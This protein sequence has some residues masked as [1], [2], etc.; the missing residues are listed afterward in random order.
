MTGH[1]I[2][3]PLATIRYGLRRGLK[4]LE[5]QVQPRRLATIDDLGAEDSLSSTQQTPGI[6]PSWWLR[7]R[8]RVGTPEPGGYIQFRVN[9]RATGRSSRSDIRSRLT[10]TVLTL[11]LLASLWSFGLER[12][13]AAKR[14]VSVHAGMANASAVAWISP[15]RFCAASDEDN[16][17]RI[18]R[19]DVDGSEV[20]HLDLSDFLSL[21][22]KS[23]EADIEG[24]ARVGNLVYWIGSHARNKDGKARPNRQRLFATQIVTNG[25]SVRLVPSGRPCES[26][27]DA[28]VRNPA[29]EG[30]GLKAAAARA[31]EVGGLNIEGM[32]AGPNGELWLGFRSPNPQGKALV[33]P[34]LNPAEVIRSEHPRFGQAQLLDLEGLGIRDMTWTGAEWYLIG[35]RAGG[36]GNARLYRWTGGDAPAER[37]EKAGFKRFN[38]EALVSVGAGAALRLMVLSDD[39]NATAGKAKRF[40]SF[41]V[42]P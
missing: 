1:L 25:A 29:L 24:G 15:D 37:V 16:V 9:P 22:G 39:G 40:R 19:V 23:L 3:R 28:L 21:R 5:G 6:T 4:V 32:A 41:W 20:D 14:E 8:G 33:V 12:G 2:Q 34:L 17:L 36:G 27:L 18:Y 11:G 35:G 31:P 38:P 42:E 30:Y 10:S 26:L 13:F 7:I